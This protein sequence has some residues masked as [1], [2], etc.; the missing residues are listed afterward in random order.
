MGRI[1]DGASILGLI[2]GVLGFWFTIR[3]VQRSRA[4]AQAAREAAE[5]A[6]RAI[7]RSTAVVE[8]SAVVATLEEVKEHHR[9]GAWNILPGKYSFLRRELAALVESYPDLT[10]PER[11]E[12]QAAIAQLRS[13]EDAVERVLAGAPPPDVPELNSVLADQVD[14][15]GRILAGLRQKGG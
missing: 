9:T 12:I 4:A 11:S 5:N 13:L 8:L 3:Q 6:R 2:V 7:V 1:A 10:R 14:R 15:L